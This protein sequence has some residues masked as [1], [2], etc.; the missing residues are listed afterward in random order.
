MYLAKF[1]WYTLKDVLSRQISRGLANGGPNSYK[2]ACTRERVAN[3]E[4]IDR[5]LI[6]SVE[7]ATYFM[8]IR[9]LESAGNIVIR[10]QRCRTLFPY[11][12]DEMKFAEQS[13][14]TF[15]LLRFPA[16]ARGTSRFPVVRKTAGL[17]F[18]RKER[19]E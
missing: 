1:F 18:E 12:C 7:K 15:R 4:K 2:I 19:S 6:S 5:N 16:Y 10:I 17:T 9:V 3:D 8:N 11:M 13:L 14:W